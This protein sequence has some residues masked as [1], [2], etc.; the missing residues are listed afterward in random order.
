MPHEETAISKTL[1]ASILVVSFTL[2]VNPAPASDPPLAESSPEFLRRAEIRFQPLN[3]A[4]GDASPKAG[5]LWGDL[6]EDVP[7]GALIEFAEGFS[8]PPHIHNITYRAVVISGSVHNDDPDA[9]HL[10]MGPGS[11]WTQPAG[12]THITAAE[13]GSKATAFLEILEGPYLVRP[14]DRAF[15]NGERPVNLDAR[16][17]VWLDASDTTWIRRSSAAKGEGPRFA[18]LW[19]R[20]QPGHRNGTFLKLAGGSSGTL[21]VGDPWLRAVVIEGLVHYRPSSDSDPEELVPGSYLGSKDREPLRI[22]CSG[23]EECL[24]YVGTEGRYVFLED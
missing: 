21:R 11:F 2:V 20:L 4:R 18:F 6:G 12:E 8:S 23:A 10:W 7:T 5:V 9:E 16:N 3:P 13:E 19:G 14:S 17:I 1:I 22:A 15:D 24:L